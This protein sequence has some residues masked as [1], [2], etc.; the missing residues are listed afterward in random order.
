MKL[1]VIPQAAE[2]HARERWC[3]AD[4]APVPKGLTESLIQH[5]ARLSGLKVR[6]LRDTLRNGAMVQFDSAV[7]GAR[8]SMLA[9]MQPKEDAQ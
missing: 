3:E 1:Q 9:R 5:V 4:W 6:V 7:F 2:E 8:V